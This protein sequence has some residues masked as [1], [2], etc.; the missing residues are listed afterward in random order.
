MFDLEQSITQWR[1]QMLAAGIKAPVPLDELEVHLRDDIEQQLKNGSTAQAAFDAAVE[2]LG[3]A[4][5]LR[6]AFKQ[7]QLDIRFPI[8]MRVYCMR[9]YCFLAAPL[10][11]SMIW[12]F[13][14]E[15]T[16]S[17]WQLVSVAAVLLIALYTSGLP[18]FYRQLFTRRIRLM[19]AAL[20]ITCPW[21]VWTWLALALLS[22]FGLIHIGNAASMVGWSVFAATFATVLAGANYDREYIEAQSAK[23]ATS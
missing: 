5:V 19:R 17:V 3:R 9:V 6:H 4:D 23:L 11:A 16:I 15:G 7:D 8:Y 18:F 20:R 13:P 21:F 12:A 2:Q 1:Q 14:A 10:V 22:A